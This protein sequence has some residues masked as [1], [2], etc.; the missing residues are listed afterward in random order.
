MGHFA[1]CERADFHKIVIHRIG[2][3]QQ[4]RTPMRCTLGQ[5]IRGRGNVHFAIPDKNVTITAK[6]SKALVLVNVFMISVEEAT[7]AKNE[8]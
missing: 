3:G 4:Q 8:V 1:A 6:A 5:G 2:R 7:V